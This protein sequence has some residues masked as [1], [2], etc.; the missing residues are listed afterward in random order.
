MNKLVIL[1][2]S[3][4]N[5]N[6]LLGARPS[7][8]IRTPSGVCTQSL[9]EQGL[10]G[11]NL[12]LQFVWQNQQFQLNISD[13][14]Y[15]AFDRRDVVMYEQLIS[16]DALSS[17]NV[18]QFLGKL[19]VFHDNMSTVSSYL[20]QLQAMM[21]QFQLLFYPQMRFLQDYRQNISFTAQ[22]DHYEEPSK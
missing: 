13:P 1:P 21:G 18:S 2:F 10:Q 19:A 12:Q 8:D 20:N 15:I 16:K 9:M 22:P 3:P 4:S 5:S 7:L 17:N 14:R 11:H 6:P